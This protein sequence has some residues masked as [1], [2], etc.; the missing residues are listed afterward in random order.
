MP[1]AIAMTDSDEPSRDASVDRPATAGR[2]KRAVSLIVG[3]PTWIIVVATAL[4][5][6]T[7]WLWHYDPAAKGSVATRLQA[8]LFMARTYQFPFALLLL[9]S[10]AVALL[11]SRG[12]L[13]LIALLAAMPLLAMEAWLILPGGSSRQGTGPVI[14]V[15]SMNVYS[16]NGDTASIVSAAR[17]MNADVLVLQEFN[18]W[19]NGRAAEIEALSEMYPYRVLPRDLS[20]LVGMRAVFSRLPIEPA[21]AHPNARQDFTRH[22]LEVVLDGGQHLAIYNVH[23]SSPGTVEKVMVNLQQAESL[24]TSLPQEEMPA[25]WLGDFN[26]PTWSPQLVGLKAAGLTEAFDAAAVGRGTTWPT[27]TH[28]GLLD[29]LPAVRLDNIFVNAGVVPVAAGVGPDTGSDHRPVWA[30]LQL[31]R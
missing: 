22:R 23:H 24:V 29:Y 11:V 17:E 4:L 12:R 1:A 9:T 28:H 21:N 18:T 15:A 3:V 31:A 16:R 6:A 30:D 2:L 19:N 20:R 14:R 25:V 27:G 5:L 10:S 13:A 26:A 7:A 8:L